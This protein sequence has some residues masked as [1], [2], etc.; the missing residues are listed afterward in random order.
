MAFNWRTAWRATLAVV[1]VVQEWNAT[2]KAKADAAARLAERPRSVW[3]EEDAGGGVTIYSDGRPMIAGSQLIVE[4]TTDPSLGTPRYL[5][6]TVQ[7]D[8]QS[9][10]AHLAERAPLAR[11]VDDRLVAELDPTSRRIALSHLV[12]ND[13]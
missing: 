5:I 6:V 10:I 11:R 3:L 4:P 12:F 2:R 13:A 8:G 9:I 1:Q 7:R